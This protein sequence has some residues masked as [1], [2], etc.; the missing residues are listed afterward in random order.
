[1]NM[2]YALPGRSLWRIAATLVLLIGYVSAQ[3]QDIPTTFTDKVYKGSGV[4]DMLIDV[5]AENLDS[6]LTASGQLILGVDLN[7]NN[8]GPESSDSLGVALKQVELLITTTEGDFTF[9]DFYTNTTA[10]ILETGA[11]AGSDY[12]TLFGE[13][14]SSTLNSS[15]T[16][17]SI[18]LMDDVIYMDNIVYSG[19]I[20]S[21]KLVVKLLDTSKTGGANESFFD[22]SGGFED[23][24]IIGEAE[25]VAI[26]TAAAGI[27]MASSELSFQTQ[28]LP[29]TLPTAPG[30]PL[31][32]AEVFAGLGF[33]IIV[34]LVRNG[35]K[36]KSQA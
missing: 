24:A 35:K 22:Y 31:P 14:G 7:E 12:Y 26:E 10:S 32:A 9:S 15:T 19:Q 6:Y 29:T 28:P 5:S 11:T 36:S 1:M 3:A 16:D 2:S 27:A 17:F 33:F 30:A 34:R 23:F 13:A 18:P 25:A 21:A 20:L 8:A 4:I